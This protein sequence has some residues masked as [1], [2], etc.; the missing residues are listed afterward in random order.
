MNE[1]VFLTIDSKPVL[2][3]RYIME[4]HLGR[5]LLDTEVVHHING[6][7][8]D[9]RIENLQIM[10][11]E[12]HS[13]WHGRDREK[14]SDVM[15]E[16][17][18]CGKIFITE[19]RTYKY[20]IKKGQINFFCSKRCAGKVKSPPKS[21]KTVISGMDE[22]IF[23]E[24]K[25]GLTPY[26]IA[27]KYGYCADTVRNH[28][29]ARNGYSILNNIDVLEIYNLIWY[30]EYTNVEIANKYNISVDLVSK[31]KYRKVYKDIILI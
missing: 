9:N 31:I 7:K 24:L 16:C 11:R 18:T 15:L 23:S 2:E 28:I 14:Q 17:Y 21:S 10:T 3:H 19:G 8:D 30:T 5:K 20:K 25:N 29:R 1:Y 4:Q 27:K 12:E 13:S 26:K 6:I 22:I